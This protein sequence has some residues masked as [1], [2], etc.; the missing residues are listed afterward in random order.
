MIKTLRLRILL[1]VLI[2]G[3]IIPV[4]VQQA[5]PWSDDE[6]IEYV[7]EF[8]TKKKG[9]KR[10]G[11]KK[12]KQVKAQPEVLTVYKA[13]ARKD[14]AILKKHE[15]EDDAQQ[16]K[17]DRLA[18]LE[19]AYVQRRQRDAEHGLRVD[20][21][22]KLST[23]LLRL[24]L[25]ERQ[26]KVREEVSSGAYADLYRSVALP[27][28]ATYVPKTNYLTATGW[29]SYATDGYGSDGTNGDITRLSFGEAP[30][31]VQ[32]IL[33]ASKLVA[34]NFTPYVNQAP[35]LNAPNL[36]LNSP[37]FPATAI[38]PVEPGIDPLSNTAN[39]T[40]PLYL[41]ILADKQISFL[42]QS[43]SWG[44]SLDYSRYLWRNHVVAGFQ[45]PIVYKKNRLRVFFADQN[46][47]SEQFDALD[48]KLAGSPTITAG[49]LLETRPD[50]GAAFSQRYGQDMS[51]FLKDVFT[52][53]GFKEYGG[54]STG[55]GDVTFFVQAIAHTN[56]VDSLMFG[57]RFLVPT[58]QKMS[59]HKL[60]APELGNGGFF[61]GSLWSLVVMHKHSY[62]NPHLFLQATL[63]SSANVQRRVPHFI[64]ATNNSAQQQYLD[65]LGINIPFAHRIQLANGKSFS[66]FNTSIKNLG[67]DIADLKLSK[68][69]EFNIRVG[70]IFEKIPFRRS[71]IDL[72]YDFRAKFRDSAT[73]LNDDDWDP[74]V[75]EKNTSQIEHK[76]GLE[77]SHQFDLGSRWRLGMEYTFS[78]Q[79]VP[80]TFTLYS[81]INYS[82]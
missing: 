15:A 7:E 49:G 48:G 37:V 39:T 54:S 69:P 36:N 19:G 66:E 57:L 47:I 42:G 78:G 4:S 64:T 33:L 71:F 53:K 68:G 9:Q 59:M 65:D 56:K 62:F 12:Q 79:N 25:N 30:I 75:F 38:I 35:Y 34:L 41:A 50:K 14:E 60:W 10:K 23:E 77:W 29:F 52:S 46:I 5:I 72:Y 55:L 61:E 58:A 26:E 11:K 45:C 32:D 8:G 74:T 16:H 67:D 6:D 21:E 51:K 40:N 43:E 81:M 18:Q 17:E 73:F 70:N 76:A 80:K 44:I 2:A 82:F 31:R 3:S 20:G 22:R 28:Y 13:E 1:F 63:S 24:W 27:T